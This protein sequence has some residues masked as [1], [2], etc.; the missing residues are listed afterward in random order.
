MSGVPASGYRVYNRHANL[1]QNADF[2][3]SDFGDKCM[4]Q[5]SDDYTDNYSVKVPVYSR[6]DYIE[7]KLITSLFLFIKYVTFS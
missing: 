6:S 5:D 3:S 1:L 4:V 2:E 7:F